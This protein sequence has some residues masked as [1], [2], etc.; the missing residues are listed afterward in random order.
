MGPHA[1]V[2]QYWRGSLALIGVVVLL[3]TDSGLAALARGGDS[4]AFKQDINL[5][6][7]SLESLAEFHVG[8]S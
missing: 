3:A 8:L 6:D 7:E 5:S 1:C 2:G 4:I